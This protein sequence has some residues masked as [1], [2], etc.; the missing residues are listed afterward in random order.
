MAEHII[1]YILTVLIFGGIAYGFTDVDDK[2]AIA[3]D[4]VSSITFGIIMV[5][6]MIINT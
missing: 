3:I 4:N 1:M 2:V 6:S 5:T